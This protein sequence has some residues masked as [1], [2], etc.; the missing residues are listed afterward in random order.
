MTTLK[1]NSLIYYQGV[2]LC[3]LFPIHKFKMCSL[4][5]VSEWALLMLSA[6]RIP[7]K[8]TK[9]VMKLIKTKQ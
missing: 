8:K 4:P 6:C 2:I 5:A 9:N 7:E 3:I 1:Q